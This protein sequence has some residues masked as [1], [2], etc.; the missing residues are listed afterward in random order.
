MIAFKIKDSE[1]C[2]DL[3]EGSVIMAAI[4]KL[5]EFA[6]PEALRVL[7]LVLRYDG[8]ACPFRVDLSLNRILSIDLDILAVSEVLSAKTVRSGQHSSRK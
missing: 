2:K 8:A 6:E 7:K 1:K 5:A 4:I 3:F